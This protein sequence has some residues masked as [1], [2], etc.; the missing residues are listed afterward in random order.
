MKNFIKEY[1][2]SLTEAVQK[3]E[4]LITHLLEISDAYLIY[5]GEDVEESR[6]L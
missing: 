6:R 5:R 1:I 3:D 4:E 2:D